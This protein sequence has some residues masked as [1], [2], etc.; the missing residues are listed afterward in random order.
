MI[1]VLL[2]LCAVMN[3]VPAKKE[4]RTFLQPDGT[5]IELM[6]VGDENLHYYI[7]KDNIPVIEEEDS[8]F[9]YARN[10]GFS[11][12]STGVLAHE[13]RL[14]SS[15]DKANVSSL[16]DV[17]HA[18]H[19][20]KAKSASNKHYS[21]GMKSSAYLGKKKGLIILA[22]FSDKQF[23]DYS[24]SDNGKATWNRYND[25]VNKEGYTNEEYGAIGSVHDYFLDQSYGKFD[26][27]FDVIGPV[28]LENTVSYYGNN[29]NGDDF[30]AGQMIYHACQ[31]VDSLVDFNDYDWDGDGIA[32]EV[33]VLYAGY[34]EATGGGAKTVWPHMWSLVEASK[35]DVIPEKVEFDGCQIDVYACSNELYSRSGYTEMGIGVFCHEF[36]HCF[37]LPDLYDTGYSNV[38]GMGMW[39]LLDAGSYNG[40]LGLG[41]VPAGY[42]SYERN[43]VGWMDFE[44]LEK[45][46]LVI[47]QKPLTEQGS[48][49]VIYNDGN[50]NEYYLLENRTKKGWDAYL[51]GKGL[52]AIHVDYD[53]DIWDSNIVNTVGKDNS[54]QR[55]TVFHA[56][57]SDFGGNEPYPYN[58][59]DSLTDN[60][61]PQ[62][63]LYNENLDGSFLMHKPV[64][65]ITI[66]EEN[67]Y[68]SF[69]FK[70]EVEK[71]IASINDVENFLK[72][73][74][75]DIYTLE[76]T[77]VVPN[78]RGD[79]LNFLPNG[80]Y[81]VKRNG[82]NAV[83]VLIW[84]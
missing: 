12:K 48:A 84:K 46:T 30:H 43:F 39:D 37:G 22:N 27:S 81:I 23:W 41:W 68:V 62:A 19:Y 63:L 6:L 8:K 31:L 76:G 57:N 50:R 58:G 47:D 17:E 1:F 44:E 18:R 32:E 42:S 52:L 16:E 65:G 9:C 20:F 14:R 33:F 35:D 25:L 69:C 4:W 34:G 64:T 59:N 13:A 66:N 82:K 70:N 38:F 40:P 56:S 54:H 21:L 7:T 36:S 3:A 79:N 24:E 28:N 78:F 77:L 83:K 80:V 2:S 55:F 61:V 26:L 73:D 49:Y 75:A 71:Y 45:D 11:L 74:K 72:N 5:T 67:D 10:V 29:V 60:S 15:L 53:P 51:P